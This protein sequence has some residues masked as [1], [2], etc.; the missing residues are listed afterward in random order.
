MNEPMP[1][2][3]LSHPTSPF[4]IDAGADVRSTLLRMSG[5]G[6][7]G[8]MLG[9]ALRV[10]EEMHRAGAFVFLGISGALVPAG[11]RLAIKWLIDSGYV[12]CVVSTGA[13]LFHDMHE[14]LGYAN[15]QGSAHQDDTE[16]RELG[17][18]RMYDIYAS[19]QEFRTVDAFIM[20]VADRHFTTER[21]VRTPEFLDVLGQEIVA[22][23]GDNGIVT[24]CHTH[25]IPLFVPA[26]GD[27]SIGIALAVRQRRG[28]PRVVFDIVGDV[29]AVADLVSKAGSTG[30]VFLG[31]GTPKNYIQQ[32]EVVVGYLTGDESGGHDFGI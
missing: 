21:I 12:H 13:Q 23:N 22:R 18:D 20:D 19:E 5:T 10:W 7:Q 32:S 6:F 29:L 14:S 4:P 28:G 11:M 24:A 9:D 30:V 3:V 31:G 26:L 2:S 17:I 1:S 27:S 25:G 16:L 8:R 15:Y